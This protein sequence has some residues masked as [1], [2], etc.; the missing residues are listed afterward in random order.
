MN[1]TENDAS[2]N[3]SLPQER[4][5]RVV[6]KQRLGDTQREPQTQTSSNSSIVACILCRGNVF[7]EPLPGN[8]R[9]DALYRAFA[10]QRQE[11]YT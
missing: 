8:E 4:L 2:K 9:R 6:T 5:Y 11:G 7:T 1:R 3:S 10:Y